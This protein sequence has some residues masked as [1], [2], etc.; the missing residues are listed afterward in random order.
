MKRDFLSTPIE[1]LKGVG[2]QKAEVLQAEI[3]VFRYGDLLRFFPFR[4]IDK[5]KITSISELNEESAA[6]QLRG[7]L[8]NI[9]VIGADRGKRIVANLVDKTGVIELLYLQLILAQK[10]EYQV[11]VK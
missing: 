4:Y 5:S 11:C 10:P 1:Y 6:I 2:P 9:R 7:K 3:N 8:S